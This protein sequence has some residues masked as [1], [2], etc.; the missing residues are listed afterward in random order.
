M[1]SMTLELNSAR[2]QA[3]CK[4]PKTIKLNQRCSKLN[5]DSIISQ[6][7]NPMNLASSICKHFQNH[8]D[9][10]VSAFTDDL[11]MFEYMYEFLPKDIVVKVLNRIPQE[12]AIDIVEKYQSSTFVYDQVDPILYVVRYFNDSKKIDSVSRDPHCIEFNKSVVPN[13][14]ILDFVL[15][16]KEHLTKTDFQTLVKT[17][18]V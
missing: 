14:S 8:P 4:N 15:R 10:L 1:S 11:A 13:G 6:V 2:N 16:C 17:I 7:Y 12:V 18:S 9:A 3:S 5:N